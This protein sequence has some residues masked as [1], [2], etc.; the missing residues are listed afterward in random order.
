[1]RVVVPYDATTPKTRLGDVLDPAER[2]AFALAMLRDVIDTVVAADGAPE[3]LATAPV[4]VAAPVT[5]DDRALTPAVNDVLA[6]ADPP[7]AIVMADLALA[8]PTALERVFATDTDLALVP[9]L[10]G[11]TNAILTR[12][13][14]F[15]V[16]Y[17]GAS[18]RDHRRIAAELGASVTMVDSMRL[19]TD[20]DEPSDLAE[21]LLH[22]D[23]RAADWVRDR[24]D[25]DTRD[26]RVTVTRRT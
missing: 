25:L 19:A 15:S 1:M 20:I 9:G 11:G 18:I 12:V 10:G 16:D 23:G 6:S 24:F 21:V 2:E 8:T 22:A 7:I 17:H 4:D 3:V 5:V 13:P 26:G 14:D